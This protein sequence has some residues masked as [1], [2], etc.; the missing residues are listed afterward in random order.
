MNFYSSLETEADD[1]REMIAEAALVAV[2]IIST[3]G[4]EA[5]VLFVF[6]QKE[7][8]IVDVGLCDGIAQ[9][10]TNEDMVDALPT[11]FVAVGATSTMSTY[12]IASNIM[13]RLFL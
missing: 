1:E 3:E 6:F 12:G 4:L 5:T 10:R 2:A 13:Q 8:G 7:G 11:A 9:I